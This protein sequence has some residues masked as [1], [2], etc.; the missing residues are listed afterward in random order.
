[1]RKQQN[2]YEKSFDWKFNIVY[3]IKCLENE[4]QQ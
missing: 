2:T 4:K 3:C 1:M